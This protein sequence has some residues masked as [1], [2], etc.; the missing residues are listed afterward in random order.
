M[1]TKAKSSKTKAAM[2]KPAARSARTS[3]AAPKTRATAP[4]ASPAKTKPVKPGSAAGKARTGGAGATRAKYS[5]T[6]APW[7]KAFL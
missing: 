6:G 7:W 4:K 5:Q 1:K 3:A 2:K